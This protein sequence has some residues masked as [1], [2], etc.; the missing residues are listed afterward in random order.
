M[1]KDVTTTI[2]ELKR[3]MA[4]RERAEIALCRSET[5]YRALVQN[6][7]DIIYTTDPYGII[8]FVNPAAIRVTEYPE[9]EIIG[10]HYLKFIHPEYTRQV[11]EFY[12][13]QL[14]EK[15]PTTYYELPAL[16]KTGKTVWL[17]QSTYL[18]ID[19]HSAV[20]FQAIARDINERKEAERAMLAAFER[21]QQIL[22]TAAAGIFIV[23][24]NRI[25]TEVNDEFCFLTGYRKE[26]IVGQPCTFF[27]QEP[28][29]RTCGLFDSSRVDPVIRRQCTIMT[30][31][32][33]ILS[34]L[35]NASAL[36]DA[37]GEIVGG[38]ESLLDVTALIEARSEAERANRAKSE[39]L[40]NMSHELRTPMNAILGFTEILLNGELSGDQRAAL[41][42]V[43]LS[44]ETL[45]ALVNDVLDLSKIEA[46]RIELEEIPF[47]VEALVM[48]ACDLVRDRIGNKP[49]DLLCDFRHVPEYLMGDPI[50]IRQVLLNLLSNALKFTEQ[51]EV[52]LVVAAVDHG[53]DSVTVEFSVHDTGIG[54]PEDKLT[55]IFDVFVQ[56]HKASEYGGTGL[57]LAICQRL[58]Q[59]MEGEISVSSSLGEGSTFRFRAKLTKAPAA[60]TGIAEPDATPELNGK[61]A[62]LVDDNPIALEILERI[63]SPVGMKSTCVQSGAE[64]LKVLGERSFDLV[65]TDIRMPGMNGYEF[66]R[67]VRRIHGK[68]FPRIVALSS[69]ISWGNREK[70]A[71]AGFDGFLMK[72]ARK[73]VLFSMIQAVLGLSEIAR[74]PVSQYSLRPPRKSGLRVLLAEDNRM[75]QKVATR[76][77]NMMGIEVDLAENGAKAVEMAQSANYDLILMDIQ[78]P[79]LDGL[80]ATRRI[81]DAKITTPIVAMTAGVMQGDREQCIE[82]GMN[83][84][85]S[86]PVKQQTMREM[87]A[88]YCG[89]EATTEIRDDLRLLLVE[90]DSD[91][92]NEMRDAFLKGMPT[93][94]TNTA[95]GAVEACV[96]LGSLLPHVLVLDLSMP[97]L[98]GEAIVEF[99]RSDRRFRN[100][101]VVATC[102]KSY[103][104]EKQ[105][106]LRAHGVSQILEKPFAVN[107][108]LTS[109]E[110]LLSNAGV[111]HHAE[112]G[113]SN[114]SFEMVAAELGLAREEY[115]D[116]LDEFVK[117]SSARLDALALALEQDEF[118]TAKRIAHTLKG[119]AAEIHI[120][121]ISSTA[122][123]IE[124]LSAVG[125][126]FDWKQHMELLRSAMRRIEHRLA[127]P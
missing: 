30:K 38:L 49:V 108:L 110:Q 70:M 118:Q 77:L 119:G 84:Y 112:E 107:A 62:L 39:F 24:R 7:S 102:A 59:L 48:D 60:A 67:A 83:D 109:V 93:A 113:G 79:L 120:P 57:G 13:K 19:G 86:K 46:D 114:A 105:E 63:L 75:N 47:N 32:G 71:N 56:A 94:S 91:L 104:A 35:R 98:N 122:F 4:E 28:C 125:T 99:M 123:T 61:Q 76:K 95:T 5:R 10:T 80:Q 87:L 11:R 100:A 43:R 14:E 68:R 54:I 26:E 58:A 74:E 97:G 66:A 69:D 85:M 21:Q 6:A 73:Q 41:E 89:L 92:L 15:I 88:R 18:L 40:A 116:L 8:T 3:E 90:S 20:G 81:R 106:R 37:N 50:R 64:A 101:S 78:L 126:A 17:G 53:D 12:E 1:E 127:G 55:E 22:T 34:S 27:A 124:K 72:P 115:L 16:T 96:K 25:V 42:S 44:T 45:Q 52:I 31:D 2:D 9:A 36:R 65:L 121:E 82:A 29:N 23:D 51:G 117:E 33:R 103:D 111:I